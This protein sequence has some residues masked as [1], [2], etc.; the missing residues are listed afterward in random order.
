VDQPSF[1]LCGGGASDVC[2]RAETN[3]PKIRRAQIAH[4]NLLKPRCLGLVAK[5]ISPMLKRV[6]QVEVPHD[7]VLDVEG[8]FV[9]GVGWRRVDGR[10]LVIRVWHNDRG[11]QGTYCNRKKPV[12]LVI[13]RYCE[14]VTPVGVNKPPFQFPH[15][16]LMVGMN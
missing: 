15:V 1:C 14:F 2:S 6:I 5:L 16:P 11:S 12:P 9:G 7:P 13:K 8:G 3:F 4:V 10:L